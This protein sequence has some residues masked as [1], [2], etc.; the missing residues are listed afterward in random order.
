MDAGNV[1]T[2]P[3]G[4][5]PSGEADVSATLFL[6]ATDD[7]SGVSDMILSHNAEF[8]DADWQAYATSYDWTFDQSRTVYVRFRDNAGNSSLTYSASLTTESQL[9]LPAI[10]SR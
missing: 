4:L 1:T 10:R 5:I 3:D 9:F 8:T 2:V 7:V 6:Q